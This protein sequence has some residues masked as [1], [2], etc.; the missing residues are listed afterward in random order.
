MKYLFIFACF[1]FSSSAVA[2]DYSFRKGVNISHWMAQH[3]EGKYAD[4]RRLSETEVEWIVRQGFDHVR[5]P[6]DGRILMSIEGKLID[7][8][9][10]PFDDALSWT[11]KHGLGVILD[12]HYL[13]GAEFLVPAE[14]NALWRDERLQNIAVSLWKQLAE[15]YKVHDDWLR[16]ELLNEAV[17]PRHSDVNS[18]NEK[19]VSAV[20][21]IDKN[22]VVYVSANEWGMFKNAEHVKVF[23]DDKNVH[24]A[25]HYYEPLIFTHQK[26]SWSEHT[27]YYK[28]SV[29]FPGTLSNLDRYFPKGHHMLDL[30]G[31]E[32]NAGQIDEDFD[33]LGTW[34]KK[35]GVQVQVSEFGVIRQADADSARRWVSAI[36]HAAER[37]GFGLTIWDYKGDFRVNKDGKP[38]PQWEGLFEPVDR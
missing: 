23:E 27:Q 30:N 32:L 7:E 37:N 33:D 20:R 3:L 12:M 25:F 17:A 4:P 15:K 5:I 6:V 21:S 22:R 35:N 10:E 19:L 1:V 28:E 14:E 2:D 11:E 16:F 26:A 34:A 36:T 29:Q 9:M 8:L 13:P 31:V 24:Y 38:T 18:L